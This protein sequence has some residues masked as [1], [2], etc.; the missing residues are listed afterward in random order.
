MT[1][2]TGVVCL[3]GH[4]VAGDANSEHASPF[5][6]RCGEPTI[7]ACPSCNGNIRGALSGVIYVPFSKAPTFCPECG[8]AFPWTERLISAAQELADEVEGIGQADIDRGKASFA[9]LTSDTPQTALA[10]A[11]V[12]KLLTKAGPAVGGAMK[13]IVTAI[14]T[15]AAK[16]LLGL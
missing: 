8:K 3:N 11:R 5:C 10:A 4:V 1:Y 6:S 13:E 12:S 15:D 9:A 7:T 2:R 14:A 16:K